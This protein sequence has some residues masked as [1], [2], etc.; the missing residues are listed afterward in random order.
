[1]DSNP[2]YPGLEAS[3]LTTMPPGQH[4]RILEAVTANHTF[5]IS[6]MVANTEF[7]NY[8]IEPVSYTHLDVYKRQV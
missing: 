4:T 6:V 8:Y 7:K 1:M 3:A 5:N 2:Q